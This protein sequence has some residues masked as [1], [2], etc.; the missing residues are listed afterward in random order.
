MNRFPMLLEVCEHVNER[1]S[2]RPWRIEGTLVPAIA[3][4]APAPEKQP[5][6]PPRQTHL[7]PSNPAEQRPAIP[8]LDDQMNVVRLHRELH[9]SESPGPSLIRIP[10]RPHHGGIH[11]L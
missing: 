7:E 11:E 5:I 8:G 9:N 1:S 10:N 2:H 3:P 4:A 6:Q